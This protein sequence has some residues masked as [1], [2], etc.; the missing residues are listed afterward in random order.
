MLLAQ[1]KAALGSL[2]RI[3]Q[4]VKLGASSIRPAI[5]PISPRWPMA[6]LN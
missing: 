6:P 3:E 1:A 5:S 4:V 2:D